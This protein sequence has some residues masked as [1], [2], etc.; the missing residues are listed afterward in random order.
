M[1]IWHLKPR[2]DRRF[3]A[4]HPWVYSNELNESPKG[5]APGSLVEL[6]DPNG[7][8]LARGYGNSSSL[9]AFRVLSRAATD[10]D[11]LTVEGVQPRIAQAMDLRKRLGMADI[12]HRLVF[13]EADQLPGLI[14][15]RYLLD[16]KIAGVN[17]IFVLQ[18]QTAGADV[19]APSVIAALRVLRPDA[20]IIT[21]F[22]SGARAM[23]SLPER[24]LEVDGPLSESLS[25]EVESQLASAAVRVRAGILRC[26]LLEGQKTGLFLDQTANVALSIQ[27]LMPVLHARAEE[28]GQPL[29]ILDLC[30]YVGQWGS[31]WSGALSA[32]KLPFELTLVD[33]SSDA[34]DLA[35]SNA[36]LAGAREVTK[37]RGDVLRDLS[38]LD[39]NS[40]DLVI[41]DPPAL[42]KGRKNIAVGT[43]AYMQLNTQVFR[44]IRAGGAVVSCSCSSLLV[45]DEFMQLLG[46]AAHRNRA[47]VSW[48]ARGA[49]SPDHPILAEFPEGR[50]LKA[51]MGVVLGKTT[52]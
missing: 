29:R 14:I 23:E 27:T 6:R 45:E 8:F 48:V 49:Q 9:I 28:S 15:D 33:A 4:G 43:H 30:T 25:E 18:P 31:A 10:A 2:A 13:G 52:Q 40:F 50:Y 46:K 44:L 37:L 17:E 47:Q 24:D 16:K 5:L 21:R 36:E 3:R 41:S 34:L 19:L 42:I 39:A 11:P 12:S 35:A 1:K 26:D 32:R 20:G 22:D 51:L 7:K 38:A